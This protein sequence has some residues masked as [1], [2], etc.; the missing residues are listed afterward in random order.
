MLSR[1]RVFATLCTAAR[2]APLLLDFPGKST[3][4]C[5]RFLLQRILLTQG[6][7]P[8]FLSPAL[9]GG[10]FTASTAWEAL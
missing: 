10:F 7:N 4:V 6:A 3:G 1:V 2:Q 9:A 8:C 5:C